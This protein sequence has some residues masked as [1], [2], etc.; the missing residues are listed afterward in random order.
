MLKEKYISDLDMTVYYTED[1]LKNNILIVE[2]TYELE[3]G[4]ETDISVVHKD[5]QHAVSHTVFF[6]KGIIDGIQLY[7]IR[8]DIEEIYNE[9][10]SVK[11]FL[12]IMYNIS[13]S[14]I[15]SEMQST[16]DKQQEVFE[17]LAEPF[18]YI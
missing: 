10:K 14:S 15:G 5:G 17:L 1:M 8:K 9:C 4:F 11:E 13:G 2:S 6:T 16:P 7:R 18:D 12:E 3:E